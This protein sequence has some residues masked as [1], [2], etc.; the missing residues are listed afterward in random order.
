MW[1]SFVFAQQVKGFSKLFKNP[2]RVLQYVGAVFFMLP[3]MRVSKAS[4]KKLAESPLF[5]ISTLTRCF[6]STVAHTEK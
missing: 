6:S 5:S 2:G 3:F 1:L 4:E